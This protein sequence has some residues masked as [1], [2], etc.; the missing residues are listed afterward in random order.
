MDFGLARI[1][2][3]HDTMTGQTGTF[4][5]MAPE[6]IS[7]CRYTE[8]ADVYSLG[9]IFWEI[10]MRKVP[11]EGLNGVQASVAVVT[12]QKRP[13]IFKEIP[14]NWQRMI[15]HCRHQRPDKRPPSTTVMSWLDKM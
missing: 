7:G 10:C 14:Q 5:W 12:Q 13:K 6:V 1:K 4:Q 3:A 11:F 2:D 15:Q 8:S 9:M